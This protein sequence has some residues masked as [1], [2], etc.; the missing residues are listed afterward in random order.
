MPIRKLIEIKPQALYETSDL[1]V[2]AHLMALG[3]RLVAAEKRSE[4]FIFQFEGGADREAQVMGFRSGA[5]LVS[6]RG[7]ADALKSLKALMRM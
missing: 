4:R 5:G 3:V 1:Y 2:S 6:G 7:F